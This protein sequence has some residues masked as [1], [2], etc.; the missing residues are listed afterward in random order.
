MFKIAS[1]TTAA[2]RETHEL[3]YTLTCSEFLYT[4]KTPGEPRM[5]SRLVSSDVRFFFP[6]MVKYFSRSVR[7]S[8]R[9]DAL[10]RLEAS[11]SD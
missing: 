8:V 11:S 2:R 6:F 5:F 9:S 4:F 3:K 1:A 10:L 7:A